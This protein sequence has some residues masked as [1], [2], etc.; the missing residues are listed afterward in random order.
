MFGGAQ[1]NSPPAPPVEGKPAPVNEYKGMQEREEVFEFSQKPA[2]KKD[3]DKWV[4]TFASKGKC[5]ATVTILGPDG[6]VV[7]RLASGVLGVNAPYPFQQ[8]SLGQ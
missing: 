2:V 7:R 8:N 1:L 3:G 4:I 5:D 6:K